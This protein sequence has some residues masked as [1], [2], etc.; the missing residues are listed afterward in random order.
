[1]RQTL[2]D[3]QDAKSDPL[4]FVAKQVFAILGVWIA[5]ILIIEVII[6]ILLG[7]AGFST[8]F[9]N[10]SGIARFFFWVFL[11]GFTGEIVLLV[12]I[13]Q[14]IASYLRKAQGRAKEVIV[15][16]IGE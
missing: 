2:N 1:M 6:L 9:G 15:D 14:R 7:I 11:V 8:W 4:I 16:V 12:K 3:I 5:L 13:K 10:P